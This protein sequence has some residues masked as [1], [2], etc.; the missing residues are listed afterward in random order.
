MIPNF[1]LCSSM[2]AMMTRS[3]YIYIEKG[4]LKEEEKR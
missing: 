1:V 2:I 3:L 4:A